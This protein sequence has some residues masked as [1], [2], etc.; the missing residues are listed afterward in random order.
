MQS[1]A[2]LHEWHKSKYM[3]LT[4]TSNEGDFDWVKWLENTMDNRVF[5]N[6][7]YNSFFHF[8]DVFHLISHKKML[9]SFL[10]ISFGVARLIRSHAQFF[11]LNEN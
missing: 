9:L 11:F 2:R 8:N 7:F 6:F 10:Y 4:P 1:G 5:G 3:L